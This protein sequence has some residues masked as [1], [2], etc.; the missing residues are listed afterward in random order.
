MESTGKFEQGWKGIPFGV[1]PAYFFSRFTTDFTVEQ[2]AGALPDLRKQG[3]DGFQLEI[4]HVDR[5]EEWEQRGALLSS[6]AREEG[7]IPTQFVGHF[8]LHGFK[9]VETLQSPFGIEEMKRVVEILGNFP[10]CKVI[11]VP[12]PAFEVAAGSVWGKKEYKDA[13]QRLVE[14]IKL[15]LEIVETA[16]F[17]M[18]LEVVPFSLLSGIEGWLK[19]RTALG[20]TTIGYNFDTGHAFS[21][22]EI[23]PLIPARMTLD[24]ECCIYGT[25]LK[26]NWG[27]ENLALAPGKGGVPWEDL[28]RNLFLGGYRGSLDLEIVCNPGQVEEEYGR[29]LRFLQ[30]IVETLVAEQVAGIPL[31]KTN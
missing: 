25:H 1:S 3:F 26:D 6:V 15:Q 24:G 5:I 9:S 17:R 18:A 12:I 16:G 23:L 21:S 2:I 19:L 31:K 20:C 7:L 28:L 10:E 29:G 22:K 4:Y 30:S 13:Y 27:T 8:L 14:K 11:T